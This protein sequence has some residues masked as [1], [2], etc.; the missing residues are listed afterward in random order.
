MADEELKVDIIPDEQ[1]NVE[2]AVTPEPKETV[3]VKDPAMLDL[4]NQY[5]ELEAK[6]KD[7]EKA[8]AEEINRR[9]AAEQEVAQHRQA[10]EVSRRRETS[11]HLDTITTALAAAEQDA[12]SAKREYIRARE[13]ND[14]AAEAEAQ[15]RLAKARSTATRLD[16]AR[17]DIEARLKRPPPQSPP[18]VPTDPVEAVAQ[19]LTAKS[20]QWVRAHPEYIHTDGGMRKLTAADAVA[21]DEGF[22]PDTPQYFERVEQYLGL[23]KAADVAD[24][25]PPTEAS[26]VKPRSTPPVAPGAAVS[27]SSQPSVTLTQG[28]AAT[29]TDGTLI[30]NYDDPTGK[31]RWKKG[32]P[33]G[34]QEMARR[35]ME[36]KKRGLYDRAYLEG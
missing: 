2:S 14:F 21:K 30:W 28:E 10:V 19:R 36:G 35:K 8:K 27:G 17:Q 12:E 5:K 23:R 25:K 33:I 1:A 24:S 6:S 15:D 4:M 31:N 7:A 32:D 20:A 13:S 18:P 29:A 22:I 26:Q 16:E 9:V 11:S 3:E 34:V